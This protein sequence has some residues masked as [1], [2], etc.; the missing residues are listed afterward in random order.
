MQTAAATPLMARALVML[1]AMPVPAEHASRVPMNAPSTRA[2]VHFPSHQP[3][4]PSP[5]HPIDGPLPLMRPQPLA[6]MCSRDGP[7]SQQLY[8]LRWGQQIRCAVSA[9]Q[10]G[11]QGSV[12]RGRWCPTYC[13]EGTLLPCDAPSRGPAIPVTRATMQRYPQAHEE[14]GPAVPSPRGSRGRNQYCQLE[15]RSSHSP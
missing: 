8:S 11:R 3:S 1:V 13:S 7:A 14:R 6:G 4:A 5:V 2:A 15:P 12:C 10:A 9:L